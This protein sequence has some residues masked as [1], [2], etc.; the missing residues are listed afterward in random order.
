MYFIISSRTVVL[1]FSYLHPIMDDFHVCGKF[2]E[3]ILLL[4]ILVKKAW[5][6]GMQTGESDI[7][8]SLFKPILIN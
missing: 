2:H 3:F 4:S 5:H 1:S 8:G 6:T 7:L